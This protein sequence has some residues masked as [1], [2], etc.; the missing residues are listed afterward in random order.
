MK[1]S[2]KDFSTKCDQ[3]QLLVFIENNFEHVVVKYKVLILEWLFKFF[4]RKWVVCKCVQNLRK[5]AIKEFTDDVFE[6]CD[7]E[8]EDIWICNFFCWKI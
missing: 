7:D 2:I 6:I 1:F 5:I 3:I 8:E 4:L